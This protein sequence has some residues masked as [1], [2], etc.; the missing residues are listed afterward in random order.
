MCHA[1]CASAQHPACWSGLQGGV[2]NVEGEMVLRDGQYVSG[3]DVML[4]VQ[5]GPGY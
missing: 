4:N 1:L 3:G 2:A 5:V